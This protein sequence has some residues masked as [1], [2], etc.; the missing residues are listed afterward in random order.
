MKGLPGHGHQSDTIL[1]NIA[2]VTKPK[3]PIQFIF[4]IPSLILPT[5]QARSPRRYLP[6]DWRGRQFTLRLMLSRNHRKPLGPIQTRW[7]SRASLSRTW[8]A[9]I[10][11]MWW[12][13]VPTNG[14]A[15][16]YIHLQ[17]GQRGARNLFTANEARRY[18]TLTFT[19]PVS[20]VRP[21]MCPEATPHPGNWCQVVGYLVEECDIPVVDQR[22]WEQYWKDWQ[23]VMG[24]WVGPDAKALVINYTVNESDGD[25]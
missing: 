9:L 12:T 15:M 1:C 22:G 4:S 21:T 24:Q 5:Y 16:S 7:H 2:A 18:W 6:M 19:H 14:W 11:T 20:L 10:G 23:W 3:S 25:Q 8:Q 13:T 17:I